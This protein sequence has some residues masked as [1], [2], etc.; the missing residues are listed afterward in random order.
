MRSDFDKEQRMPWKARE[1]MD[2]RTEFVLQALRTKNFREL[3]RRYGISAKTGYKWMNRLLEY[4]MAE[5]SR[6]PKTNS[7][8]L[9]EAVV[10]E[11]VR[12]KERHRSGGPR[13]L[14]D[15]YARVHSQVPSESS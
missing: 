7:R 12:L 15:I 4:G 13:K 1:A 5:E 8:G 10:C 3:C 9:E 11:I 14:R 6:R 2:L